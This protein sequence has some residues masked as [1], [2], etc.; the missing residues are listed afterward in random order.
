MSDGANTSPP[1]PGGAIPTPPVRAIVRVVAVVVAAALSLY[2]IYLLRQPIGWLVLA[3]FVALATAGPIRFLE[4]RLRRGPAVALVFLGVILAPFLIL[5]VLVPPVVE[6]GSRLAKDAPRYAADARRIASENETLR[7]LDRRYALGQRLQAAA[8]R[9]TSRLGQAAGTLVNVGAGIVSSVFA[10]VTILIL[11]IFMVTGAP[12]WKRTLASYQP[13]GREEA[14]N[15]LFDRIGE[16]V[17]GYVRGALLQ[18]LI[19]GA[20]SWVVLLLLGIPYALPLAL[21]VGLLD[22]VPL[23]GATLG[24]VVVGIVT[25]F[26]DFPTATIV[27]VVWSIVYQQLENAVIQPRIMSRTVAVDP[28]VVLVSVLFG[29]ALFGV[30]GALLAIPAAATVQV[31]IREYFAYRGL[32]RPVEASP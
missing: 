30:I 23:V 21:V 19:A 18:A 16:A 12:R 9:L 24:A 3:G 6:Q 10:V 8:S 22:L 27:W 2:L 25:L 32:A 4:R 1:P 15:R 13:P 31:A 7:G 26:V 11:A 5:A 29:S 17:G 28:F 20:L 14:L